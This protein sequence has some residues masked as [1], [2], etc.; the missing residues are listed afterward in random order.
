MVNWH[1]FQSGGSHYC[2]HI[3]TLHVFETAEVITH[4]SGCKTCSQGQNPCRTALTEFGIKQV[5]K[6]RELLK[7]KDEGLNRRLDIA[8]QPFEAPASKTKNVF[9]PRRYSVNLVEDCNMRCRYCYA[10]YGRYSGQAA[11]MSP[12]MVNDCV[13][14][15]EENSDGNSNLEVEF[16][17][18]EPTL[19]R[20]LLNHFLAALDK[21]RNR[22]SAPRISLLTNG[23]AL[24]QEIIQKLTARGARIRISMDGNPEDHDRNRLDAAGRPTASRVMQSIG[25][26]ARHLTPGPVND[27][28]VNVTCTRET[29][30]IR[31]FE[32]LYD[33]LGVKH[34]VFNIVRDGKEP[35]DAKLA[36]DSV[37][38]TR[39]AQEMSQL[40]ERLAAECTLGQLLSGG[41]PL[42]DLEGFW[43]TLLFND[44]HMNICQAGTGILNITVDGHLLPCEVLNI[45]GSDFY[46]GSL[47]TGLD[48]KRLAEFRNRI[49]EYY[50]TCRNCWA[51]TLCRS[52]CLIDYLQGKSRLYCSLYRQ[53]CEAALKS[54]VTF[55]G[56]ENFPTL[57]ESSIDSA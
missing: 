41:V 16:G 6:A 51:R 34:V 10:H 30:P 33:E 3:P 48:S 26:L 22:N 54:Y 18:G 43:K 25:I 42:P 27:L 17:G 52:G 12:A 7:A 53:L 11:K 28:T 57:Q 9:S 13:S 5:R 40:Y 46:L 19:D 39:Y 50:Q 29:S 36:H 47:Q 49:T 55:R 32:F 14:F 15:I 44:A 20:N 21:M 23:L 1:G 8:D 4:V 31:A 2:I 56:K 37:S 24:D 35:L 45:F 38:L